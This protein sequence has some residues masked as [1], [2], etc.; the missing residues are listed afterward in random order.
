MLRALLLI[1][2]ASLI[3]VPLLTAEPLAPAASLLG[4]VQDDEE[5]V[6]V[7]ESDEPVFET[8]LAAKDHKKIAKL[9]QE[10]Y[11]A[12]QDGDEVGAREDLDS[13]IARIEKRN[14][15][16]QLVASPADLEQ[17][18]LQ[19]ISRKDNA[20]KGRAKGFQIKDRE[21]AWGNAIPYATST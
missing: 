19:S 17:I 7:E 10:F 12:R 18:I 4:S 14:E 20:S 1:P 16:F 3:A 11:E 6:E 21:S 2:T 9:L 15:G 8:Q 5:S 13:E